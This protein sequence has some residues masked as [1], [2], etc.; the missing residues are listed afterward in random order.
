MNELNDSFDRQVRQSLERLVDVPPRDPQAAA[1]G[2]AQFLA[3]AESLSRGAS[4]ASAPRL[5][6]WGGLLDLLTGK[7]RFAL[8]PLTTVLI[9]ALVL[10]G[11]GTAVYAAQD[12]LPTDPLY[13]VKTLSEDVRLGLTGDPEAQVGLSLEFADRRVEEIE[14]LNRMRVVPPGPLAARLQ[15]QLDRALDAAAGLDDAGMNRALR[16]AQTTIEQQILRMAAV[17]ANAPEHAQPAVARVQTMLAERRA[18]VQLGL[19]D[20]AA[21]RERERTRDGEPQ[22]TPAHTPGSGIG[23]GLGI[24]QTVTPGGSLGPGPGISQTVAPTNGLGPGISQTATPGGTEPGPGISQTVTPAGGYGPGPQM[25]PT[26][27]VGDGH[28]EPTPA[29]GNLQ[30]TPAPGGGD[31]PQPTAVPGGNPEPT[32]SGSGGGGNGGDPQP[33]SA[34]GGGDTP[35]PTSAPGG[36]PEPTPG[37]GGGGGNSSDPQPTS[38]PGGDSPQPTPGRGSSGHS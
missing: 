16:K 25:T 1:R 38:V 29:G 10:G 35:Q 30:P 34:P 14:A 23:P 27:G 13:R 33:T 31:A 22:P 37:S 15:A 2:R 3:Q 17:Q 24:S 26:P 8:A 20:P 5:T 11:A 36:D 32:P 21:F 18:L 4:R 7:K 28:P 9:V 19:A 6:G 12:D